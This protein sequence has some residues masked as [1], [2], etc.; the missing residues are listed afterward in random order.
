MSEAS[1][2]GEV[3]GKIN[4]TCAIAQASLQSNFTWRGESFTEKKR[5]ALAYLFLFLSFLLCFGL[6]LEVVLFDYNLFYGYVFEKECRELI[7]KSCLCEV[8]LAVCLEHLLL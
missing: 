8:F 5:Y 3:K 6:G 1:P 7:E 4:F 2:N